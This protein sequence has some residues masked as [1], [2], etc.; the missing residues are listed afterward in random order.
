MGAFATQEEMGMRGAIVTAQV[1]KPDL[2]IVFE[3]SPSDDFHISATQAQCRMK[4]GVQIRRLDNSYISN[5]AFIEY[6]EELAKKCGIPY[7][8]AVRRGGSTN[9]GKISLTGKA[10]PVLVLGIPSRYIH[11]HYNFCAREDME[12]ASSLAAQVIRGL[13]E[14]RLCHIFRQDILK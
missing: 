11:T 8:E 1:V 9:A 14:E 6:A 13:D 5:P 4:N 7:Q 10:V 3:G 12:A 2:A